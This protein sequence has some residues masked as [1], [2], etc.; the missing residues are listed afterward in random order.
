MGCDV[1]TREAFV[2]IVRDDLRLPVPADPDA[3][4]VEPVTW[5][6][7]NRVRLFAAV[8]RETGV[9]AEVAALFAAGTAEEALAAFAAAAAADREGVSR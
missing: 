2:R 4:F 5:S 1:L 9:R 6:S 3:F 8:E 7:M